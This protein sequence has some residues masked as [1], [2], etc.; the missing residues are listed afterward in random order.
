[1]KFLLVFI[2]SLNFCKIGAQENLGT[3]DVIGTSPLP[4]ILIDRKDVPHTSQKITETQIQEN[5]TKSITDLINENFS[6]ISTA[7]LKPI[8]PPQS[9]PIKVILFRSRLMNSFFISSL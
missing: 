2:V 9:C 8:G 4:G 1:M 7:T 6:G 5:L 3:V